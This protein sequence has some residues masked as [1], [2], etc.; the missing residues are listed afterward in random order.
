MSQS[1]QHDALQ[2]LRYKNFKVSSGL[3]EIISNRL[4]RL[5]NSGK[6]ERLQ[7]VTR[8]RFR[9]QIEQMRERADFDR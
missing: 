3:D 8:F 7:V 4:R 6:Q 2:I 5:R 9:E 1:R